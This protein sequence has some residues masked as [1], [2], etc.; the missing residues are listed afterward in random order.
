MDNIIHHKFTLNNW[1]ILESP[2]LSGSCQTF[3]LLFGASHHISSTSLT[4][5]LV[6][7]ASSALYFHIS[8]VLLIFQALQELPYAGAAA[9]H[10]CIETVVPTL[11][12]VGTQRQK[13][14]GCIIM[15]PTGMGKER[16]SV[17]RTNP[18]PLV[19]I[20]KSCHVLR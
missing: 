9:G 2:V 5:A 14:G 1:Y 17:C 15:V 7:Q 11:H 4:A 20:D 13:E 6:I 8:D 19:I 12:Y 3:V 16:I 10:H 18:N